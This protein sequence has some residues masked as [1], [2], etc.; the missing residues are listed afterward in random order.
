MQQVRI[1]TKVQMSHFPCKKRVPYLKK[2]KHTKT[3]PLF[4]LDP[5]VLADDD[6]HQIRWQA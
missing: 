4:F 3:M 2:I 6:F 1:G 5:D